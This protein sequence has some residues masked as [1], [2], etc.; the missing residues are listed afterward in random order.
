M[1]TCGHEFTRTYF[2]WEEIEDRDGQLS[3]PFQQVQE[4]KKCG[5][6]RREGDRYYGEDMAEVHLK[7]TSRGE[8]LYS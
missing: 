3:R 7:W 1:G 5:E 8:A 4:C 2:E 6:T